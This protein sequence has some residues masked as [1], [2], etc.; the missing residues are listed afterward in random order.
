[1]PDPRPR[2]VLI[3]PPGAGK[4]KVAKRVSRALGLPFTDTDKAIVAEHGEIAAIFSEHGEAHFRRLERDAVA[5]ALTTSGV[6]SLGGGAVLDPRTQADL[7]EHTVVLLTVSP[8]AVGPRIAGAKR[9]LLAAGGVAAWSALVEQRRPVYEA[10]ADATFDTSHTP[11]DV[12]AQRVI[13][14]LIEEES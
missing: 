11:M 12:V 6:V 4:T 13:D 10:L 3:G 5:A 9:P 2:L 1:M 7:G 14:W 8:E